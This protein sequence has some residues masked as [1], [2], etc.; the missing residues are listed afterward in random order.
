MYEDFDREGSWENP[1]RA[2]IVTLAA[3]HGQVVAPAAPKNR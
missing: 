2:H 1:D 3:R